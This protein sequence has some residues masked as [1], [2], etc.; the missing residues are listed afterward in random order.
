MDYLDLNQR[1]QEVLQYIKKVQLQKGYPPTVREIGQ[2]IAGH[3]AWASAR[4][5]GKGLY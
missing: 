5:G 3:C 1:Q 4:F 2:G